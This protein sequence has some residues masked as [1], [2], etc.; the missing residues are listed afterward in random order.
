M[1]YAHSYRCSHQLLLGN[2]HLKVAI[3][4]SFGKLVSKGRVAYLAIQSNHVRVSIAKRLQR[5]TIGLASGNSLFAVILRQLRRLLR[6]LRGRLAIL[7][8]M[9]GEN[10]AAYGV[11]LLECLLFLLR[12][13]RFAMPAIDILQERD[14]LALDLPANNLGRR[15]IWLHSLSIRLVYLFIV[16]PIDNDSVPAKSLGTQRIGSC[17][18]PQLG[19]PALP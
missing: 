5:I 8:L 14:A 3:G 12:I 7:R 16:V 17:I 15:T 19:F 1:P 6:R 13:E 4:M 2:V 10:L 18:P 9:N 11:K